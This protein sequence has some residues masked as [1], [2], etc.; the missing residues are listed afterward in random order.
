M[1]PTSDTN[2][3]H[4]DPCTHGNA[5]GDCA[6]V[7]SVLPDYDTED[8]NLL[9]RNPC[10]HGNAWGDCGFGCKMNAVGPLLDRRPRAPS[11]RGIYG[12]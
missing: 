12:L 3:I 7:C 2:L 5:F 9:L 11:L 6:W 10:I 4:R 8:V 1:K